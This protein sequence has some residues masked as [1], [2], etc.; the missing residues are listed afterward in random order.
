ML[1]LTGC[2]TVSMVSS[3]GIVEAETE[4]PSSPMEVSSQAFQKT[5]EAEGWVAGSRGLAGLASML[6]GGNAEDKAPQ[7]VSYA[8]RLEAETAET[9][10]VFKMIAI[11]AERA[12]EDMSHLDG[13]AETLLASGDVPRADL[14]SFEQALVTAQ[15][16]YRSFAEATG[17]A[18]QRNTLGLPVAEASLKALAAAIDD[19]RESADAMANAYAP[20]GT[21]VAASS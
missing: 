18:E 21:L 14:I 5:A 8:E 16:S 7:T 9:S 20:P 12:A 2:A 4:K 13:L 15:K 19:A 17:I 6:F 10:V 11:D 1:L 3:Q